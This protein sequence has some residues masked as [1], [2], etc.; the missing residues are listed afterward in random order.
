MFCSRAIRLRG[1]SRTAG[2]LLGMNF[3]YDIFI[4]LAS[5]AGIFVGF[6]ALITASGSG[7]HPAP[8]KGIVNIGMLSLSASLIPV[9]LAS[10]EIDSHLLWR[11]SSGLFLF[12]IWYALLHPTTRKFLA[13]QF[14]ID[15]RAALIFWILIETPIQ[16]PLFLSL[17]GLYPQWH[18]A[19]YITSIILNLIQAGYLLVQYVHVPR[20]E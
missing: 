10:Y 18:H 20:S 15:L 6:A 5:I 16:V 9:L 4:D 8:L 2:C 12:L 3:N 11:I 14:R 19:F 17:L 13:V 7:R 1:A